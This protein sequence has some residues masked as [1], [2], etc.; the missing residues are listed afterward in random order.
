MLREGMFK[1]GAI[2]ML[3][4]LVVIVG[5]GATPTS[6]AS[7]A[8]DHRQAIQSQ[9]TQGDDATGQ[10]ST[11]SQSQAA[12]TETT[13]DEQFAEIARQVPAFGGLFYDQRG[14]L[15]MYLT[16]NKGDTLVRA[17]AAITPPYFRR[18]RLLS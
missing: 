10:L 11:P 18:T 5:S 3:V 12:G 15:T 9:S 2:L 14:Q 7:A 13:L 1:A 16:E 17:K 4:T 8:N 6:P